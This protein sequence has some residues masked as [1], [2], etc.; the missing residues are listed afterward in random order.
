MFA[1]SV[2]GGIPGSGTDRSATGPAT[3]QVT[4]GLDTER[5]GDSRTVLGCGVGVGAGAGAGVREAGRKIT[6]KT[7]TTV[8]M[9][10]STQPNQVRRLTCRP[11]GR[12]ALPIPIL[13]A[14]EG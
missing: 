7:T 14:Y 13:P 4:A 3:G 6:A 11:V 5:A 12:L 10:T 1:G 8:A 9:V 2:T